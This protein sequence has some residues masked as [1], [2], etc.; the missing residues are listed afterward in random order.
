MGL[1]YILCGLF[2]IIST[3]NT[4][5]AL[6]PNS[7]FDIHTTDIG[8][9]EIIGSKFFN[10]KTG[11]Q[12][13]LK[14]VAYQPTIVTESWNPSI[15]NSETKFVDPLAEPSLC[16]RDLPFFEKLNV[17]TLRVY[18][19][20]TE[21][22][23]DVCME[24]LANSGIY[25]LIDLSEPDYSIERNQ[26]SWDVPIF[27]R[28]TA[29]VDVMQKFP[30]V[31]GF[32]AGNEVT[33]D[34]TNTNASPFVK[35]AIRDVKDYIRVKG[36]REIPV[37][38]SSNDDASTRDSLAKYFACGGEGTADFYGINMYEWCGYSSYATSGYRERTLE[39]SNYPIPVFLSEFGC[40]TVRPR[41]FTEVSALFGPKMSPVW[42]GGLVY[43][44]FEEENGYGLVEI[45]KSGSVHELEDF[46]YLQRAYKDTTP[47]GT[48]KEKYLRD[49]NF[50]ISAQS[51]EC[52]VEASAANSPNIWK[53]SIE[54]PPSPNAEICQCLEQTLPCF[55]APFSSG[56]NYQDH[57]DYAC[58]QVDCSDIT[59][60]GERG[61]YGEFSYC[62]PEQ[63]LALQISKMYHM[64]NHPTGFC[65]MSSNNVFFNAKSINITSPVCVEVSQRLQDSQNPAG[66]RRTSSVK[67]LIKPKMRL[68]NYTRPVADVDSGSAV[69]FKNS[70]YAILF[71]S[72]MFATMAF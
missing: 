18:S 72:I 63:K 13:F 11:E 16:L 55:V 64:R 56:W 25:V 27:E 40:N 37:G 69:R 15:L 10:S 26:P 45:D 42:S 67:K 36:Y 30:N 35:A 48:T 21:R 61:I 71:I 65:P 8:P 22:N 44:Y 70:G 1:N 17:N 46:K 6:K 33:N 51:I 4:I 32:F 34:E 23:H 57:F 12:F 9:I 39:F 68:G 2:I 29:V 59:T 53:A 54:M 50:A 19:I 58:S 52:P 66:S 60:D 47:H 41:P 3:V 43:M 31:L 38:Y 28:Y 7:A 14:G 49:T 62:L 20:D 5:S 24:A